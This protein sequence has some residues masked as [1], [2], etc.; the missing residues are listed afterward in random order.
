MYSSTIYL[1]AI[2]RIQ[3]K[4]AIATNQNPAHLPLNHLG[5]PQLGNLTPH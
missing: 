4:E 1:Y 5:H 3:A 2:H